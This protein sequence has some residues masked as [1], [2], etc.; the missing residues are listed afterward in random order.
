VT[1]Q[2]LGMNMAI[3]FDQSQ[4]GVAAALKTTGVRNTRWPGGSMSDE[5][6]WRTNTACRT[7]ADV[8]LASFDDFITKVVTPGGLDLAVTVNYGS[9]EA[10]N[11][12]GDPAESAGWVAYAK[13]HGVPVSHWTVGN[14]NYGPWE[15]D[16][17]ATPH[18]AATYA[19]AVATG[20]Y[21]AMKAADPSA[22]VGVVVAPGWH[23]DWDRI[24]L[25]KARY[26]FVELHW[27]A[28]APGKEDDVELLTLAPQAFTQQVATLRGELE[29]VGR[30]DTPIYVG[31]V[32]SVAFNPGKQTASITQALFAGQILGELMK[33]G[34]APAAWWLGFGG[35]ADATTGNFGRR[36]YG[37]QDFGGY[38]VFS[39]G[40]PEYGCRTAK[41]L[42]F[43]TPLPTARAFQLLS[44]VAQNGEHSLGA[45]LDDRSGLLRAYAVTRQGGASL[46]LFN[47]S[48]TSPAPV[49]VTVKGLSAAGSV[50]M[51]VYDKAIYDESRAQVWAA[52]SEMSLG[53]MALPLVL[54]LPPW[55]MT[56]LR[57][58]Q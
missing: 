35:C 34:V 12:G 57:L 25:A 7:A 6:H 41:P 48:Q 43:G 37:W 26:D 52:P 1:D 38:M 32:G 27:Y 28:Q 14:E 58:S 46:V 39:D 45:V 21:P 9:N 11:A 56:V 24:V 15:F 22:T 18:D 20:F 17:H 23:P 40:V 54:A 8:P 42:A 47:L 33:A 31:E 49:R 50:V 10:C 29:S 53:P 5:Y 36:L 4:S 13:A 16:L 3:W 30:G 19:D 55:S 2:I 44:L 51:D